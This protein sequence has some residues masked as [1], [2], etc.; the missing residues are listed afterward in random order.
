MP[1]VTHTF[2]ARS[3]RA[4]VVGVAIWLVSAAPLR[5]DAGTF[6]IAV[7]PD[8]QNYVD[9]RQQKAAGFPL[10]SSALFLEQMRYLA[11]RARSR[12]G[13]IVF[14]LNLGDMKQHFSLDID[15]A[16]KA[17]GLKRVPNP[18]FGYYEGPTPEVR[19]EEIPLLVRGYRMLDGVLPFSV[20]PGN[21]DYDA[22]W[23]DAAH[24]P[25]PA[26]GGS[27]LYGMTRYTGLDDFCSAFSDQSPFFKGRSWYV[28]SHDC[29]A[30]SAQVFEAGGYRILHIGLQFNAPDGSLAW[31]RSVIDRFP[32]L[33]T[34]ISTHHYLAPNGERGREV[35]AD[36]ER[37]QPQAVWDKLIAQTDQIFLV[38]SG[39]RCTQ[40]F[41]SEANARGHR[42]YQILSDY[43]CRWQVAKNA[44]RTESGVGL[45]DG[46][47]RL[48]QFDTGAA[49][50][51]V[52]VRTYSTYFKKF[53]TELPEYA[54][55]YKPGERPG[56]SDE[57][58]LAVDDFLLELRDFRA[59]FA[60]AKIK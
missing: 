32:R 49:V 20:V 25:D 44:G 33:P 10:D 11:D 52:H 22:F 38:L 16:S 39:H 29:G 15:A 9:Y 48:L 24:P 58:F 30:D 7:I 46:W 4:V 35:L 5:S 50:P 59:R 54:E 37:N 27:Y 19:R 53:S 3:C 56:Y 55:W 45:G 14:A 28:A 1:T 43:Q 23:T 6:T 13:E 31:A 18:A 34:I 36:P 12:G 51:T 26:K 21:H 8:T 42:V 41:R 40:G 2:T 17:R 60:D 57:E 47:L